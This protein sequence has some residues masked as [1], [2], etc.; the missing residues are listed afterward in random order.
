[1]S[2]LIVKVCKIKEVNPHAAADRLDCA[3]VNGWQCV[4][5]KDK[6]KA[7]DLIVYFPPD[8]TLPETVTDELGVSNYCQRTADQGMRIRQVRLRGEPSFGLIVDLPDGVDWKEGDT[9]DEHYGAKKYDPP[10]KGHGGDILGNNHIL[11]DKFTDIQNLRNFVD[12]FEDGEEVV[13]TEKIHGT[14]VRGI[15]IQDETEGELLFFGSKQHP[16]T[17]PDTEEE[18]K[19]HLYW[20]PYTLQSVKDMFNDL[21]TKHK[22]IEIYGETY[23]RVQSLKYGI[24]GIAFRCFGLKLDGRYVDFDE[25]VRICE[26]YG[27]PMVPVLY[28]G[29]YSLEKIKEVSEGNTTVADIDQIREGT[30]VQPIKERTHP[31]IGRLILKYVSDTYLM[32]KHAERDTTDA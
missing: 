26:K 5:S 1:M 4:V 19:S 16:R 11:F 8:T 12:V 3:I 2:I 32:G 20:L 17:R 24:N 31:A 7:D 23:G 18:M 30:V 27:V 10:V 9:V 28:R 13:C 21:K 14:C 25:R 6:Y 29:P 15:V 22:V